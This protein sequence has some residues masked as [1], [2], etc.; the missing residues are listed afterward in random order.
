MYFV[1]RIHL[2][3]HDLLFGESA[4]VTEG[5]IVGF[6]FSMLLLPAQVKN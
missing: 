4:G 1:Y 5:L 3:F 2:L 6:G